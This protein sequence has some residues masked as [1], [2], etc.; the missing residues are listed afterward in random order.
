MLRQFRSIVG[1]LVSNTFDLRICDDLLRWVYDHPDQANIVERL[2]GAFIPE[3]QEFAEIADRK[4]ALAPDQSPRPSFERYI[5]R[6][7]KIKIHTPSGYLQ[8]PTGEIVQDTAWIPGNITGNLPYFRKH[9]HKTIYKEG[10]WFSAIL[11]W[12]ENYYHWFC[13]VLPRFFGVLERLPGETRFIVP[14]NMKRWQWQSLEAIGISRERCEAFDG[15]TPWLLEQFLYAPPVMMTG[16]IEKKSISWV[17]SK[18]RH[19]FANRG[20][21][22][23]SFVYISRKKAGK[24]RIVNEDELLPLLTSYGFVV[25]YAEDH[26]LSEQVNTFSDAAMVIAPHGAGLTNILH[27]K[28]GTK[29]LEIFDSTVVRRCYRSLAQTL[30]LHH[31]CY[32][33]THVP[34][35]S[36]SEGDMHV[37]IEHFNKYFSAWAHS[38]STQPK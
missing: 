20:A 34:N 27:C 2:E 26:T 35:P 21:E 18:L 33:A 38:V 15:T 37:D 36:D 17:R 22:P 24:R 16:D 9:Q 6:I 11:Y 4:V 5:A 14:A 28:P 12:S 1:R 7:S 13:D 19:A 8:L 31:S 25:Y 29:V 3:Y 10:L 23:S 32:L 30:S